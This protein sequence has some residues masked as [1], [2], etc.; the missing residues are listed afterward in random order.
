VGRNRRIP[1]TG[2]TTRTATRTATAR[3]MRITSTTVSFGD[4][5]TS[6]RVDYLSGIFYHTECTD[7]YPLADVD[8]QTT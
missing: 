2:R 4:A 7:A 1:H 3:E 8:E 5:D 6:G